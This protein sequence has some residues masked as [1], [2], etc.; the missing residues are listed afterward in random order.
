MGRWYGISL[1]AHQ[2]GQA[3]SVMSKRQRNSDRNMTILSYPIILIQRSG[4]DPNNY[5]KK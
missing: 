1:E 3:A 5:V 2:D 4:D